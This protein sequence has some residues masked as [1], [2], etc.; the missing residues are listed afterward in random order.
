M[1]LINTFVPS[2]IDFYRQPIE[3]DNEPTE[4]ISA[5][6]EADVLTAAVMGSKAKSSGDAIYGSVSVTDVVSTIKGALVHNDEASRVIINEGD[7]RF[8]SGL[9]EEGSLRVKQLG[10]FKV[11]IQLQGTEKP[12]VRNIRIRAKDSKS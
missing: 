2:T 1:E 3:K 7:V 8:I 6:G 9:E 12:L 11:E 5:S 10:T 4:R